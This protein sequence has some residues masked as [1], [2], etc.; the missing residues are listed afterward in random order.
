MYMNMKILICIGLFT[1]V[2]LPNF[3]YKCYLIYFFDKNIC[4]TYIWNIT[5][6]LYKQKL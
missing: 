1:L 3:V 6:L 4:F 5:N 2:I